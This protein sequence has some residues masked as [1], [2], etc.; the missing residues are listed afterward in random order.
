[1]PAARSCIR[2]ESCEANQAHD[3]T[4]PAPPPLVP[5]LAADVLCLADDLWRLAGR[6]GEVDAGPAAG[7]RALLNSGSGSVLACTA[8]EHPKSALAHKTARRKSRN[9]QD[10]VSPRSNR[11]RVQSASAVVS[12]GLGQRSARILRLRSPGGAATA[13]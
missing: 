13:R 1:M 5:L 9:F 7:G 10:G 6:A 11:W 2:S 4:R 12:G 8:G 3:R